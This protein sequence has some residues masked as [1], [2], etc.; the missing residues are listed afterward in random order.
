MASASRAGSTT[1]VRQAHWYEHP[2]LALL[3]AR[4]LAPKGAA[5]PLAVACRRAYLFACATLAFAAYGALTVGRREAV[6]SAWAL[7][8]ESS[9]ALRAVPLIA[10][11]GVLE[12]GVLYVSP[13]WVADAFTVIFVGGMVFIARSRRARAELRRRRP[14]RGLFVANLA[15]RRPGAGREVLD[16]FLA[17]AAAEDR[18]LCLE[19]PAAP[20]LV[21]FYKRVGLKVVGPPVRV[22]GRNLVYMEWSAPGRLVPFA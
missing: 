9:G 5:S 20:G 6:G 3:V 13:P 22:G 16:A 4:R 11:L 7:E 12:L 8:R 2:P 17:R 18:R 1:A 14:P 15:S 19:A 21:A 10:L